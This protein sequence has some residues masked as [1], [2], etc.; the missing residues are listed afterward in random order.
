MSLDDSILLILN[1]AR[2]GIYDFLGDHEGFS[3]F[4]INL[5]NITLSTLSLRL[6]LF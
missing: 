2:Q 3:C 1:E 5:C 6:A 4:V